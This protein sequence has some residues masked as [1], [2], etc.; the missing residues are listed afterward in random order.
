DVVDKL[1]DE[2]RLADAGAAEQP[3]LAAALERREQIDRLDAGHEDF[4]GRT[5]IYKRHGRPVKR[6]PVPAG[7]RFA[8]VERVAEHI[9]DAPEQAL[10]DR[11]LQ[12]PARIDDRGATSK[13]RSRGQRN[14]AYRL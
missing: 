10:T 4:G 8:A 11:H 13:P 3:G 1:G 6:T 7:E 14:A 12:R 2:D 5:L 9:D